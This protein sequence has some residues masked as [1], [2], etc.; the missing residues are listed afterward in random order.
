[1]NGKQQLKTKLRIDLKV[2][3][4]EIMGLMNVS[5]EGCA[6]VAAEGKKLYAW[7]AE[8]LKTDPDCT[9]EMQL[10]KC[11]LDFM[12][13]MVDLAMHEARQAVVASKGGA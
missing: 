12:T 10:I 5:Q 8:L 1:M 2:Y 4:Q 7:M 3:K 13:T 9:C 6:V 11:D